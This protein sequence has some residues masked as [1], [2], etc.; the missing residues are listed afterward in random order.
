MVI[1]CSMAK[2]PREDPST[3]F[4][5]TKHQDLKL[6]SLAEA[7]RYKKKKQGIGFINVT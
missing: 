4:R 3:K 7:E 6:E 1:G 5:A 2:D